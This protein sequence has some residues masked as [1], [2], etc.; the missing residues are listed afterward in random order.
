MNFKK[1]NIIQNQLYLIKYV[2]RRNNF[3]FNLYSKKNNKFL[4]KIKFFKMKRKEKKLF[5]TIFIQDINCVKI[6]FIEEAIK[7]C[8]SYLTQK[9]GIK[10]FYFELKKKNYELINLLKRLNF[11]FFKEKRNFLILKKDTT[12][13]NLSNFSI[14]SAQFGMRYGIS[15]P[16]NKPSINTIRRIIN[17]S[18]NIG[19]HNIDTAISYGNS[20]KILGEVGV[21]DFNITTKLPYLKSVNYRMIENHIKKSIK[22][23]KVDSLYAVLLHSDKNILKGFQKIL[24]IL[25]KIKYNGLVNNIGVSITNFD[26]LSKVISNKYV[27]II[28]VPYNLMDQRVTKKIF[29][30]KIKKNKIKIQIRS[31]FLQGLFFKSFKKI[32]EIFPNNS[33]FIKKYA[34]V[35]TLNK[36]KKLSYLLNFIIK[37]KISKQIVIGF[38][39]ENQLKQLTRIKIKKINYFPNISIKEQEKNEELIN[40]NKWN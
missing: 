18:R 29:L 20:E 9:F 16:K 2:D 22:R 14:G 28:Q 8:V 30:D 5:L 6:K 34:K 33:A 10:F 37:N 35:L 40:P 12:L 17:L 38:D 1:F 15:K 27:D 4:G 25:R 36:N 7:F 39:N 26:T 13:L 11:R 3:F 19:V 21:S 23:L 24:M 32:K 31:I